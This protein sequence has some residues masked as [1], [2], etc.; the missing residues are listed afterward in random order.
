MEKDFRFIGMENE[1]YCSGAQGRIAQAIRLLLQTYRVILTV[2]FLLI[3]LSA[4]FET[5]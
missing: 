1:P 3:L 4:V 5:K 2:I